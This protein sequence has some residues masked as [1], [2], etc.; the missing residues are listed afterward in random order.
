MA[1]AE[2]PLPAA[3]A[4]AAA[5]GPAAVL[6]GIIAAGC[7][8]QLGAESLNRAV[9]FDVVPSFTDVLAR[10]SLRQIARRRPPKWMQTGSTMGVGL[11][12]G[13]VG[14]RRR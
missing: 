8:Y 13:V 11:V 14:R 5:S 6:G 12:A 2:S 7:L 3:P 9:G 1:I 4:L 10:T